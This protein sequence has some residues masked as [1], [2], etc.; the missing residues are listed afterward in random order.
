[1]RMCDVCIPVSG[2]CVVYLSVVCQCVCVLNMCSVCA[3]VVLCVY[4]A[5]FVYLCWDCGVQV[6]LSECWLY[7]G[8]Y[9]V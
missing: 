4:F 3:R 8:Y 7:V 1:M 6:D 9:V 5:C 2:M